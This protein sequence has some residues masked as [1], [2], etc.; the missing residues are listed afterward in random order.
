MLHK[1][2]LRTVVRAPQLFF[3]T[4][5]T[6]VTL[7]RFSQDMTLIDGALPIAA[8]T[9]LTCLWFNL[10]SGSEYMLMFCFRR[11]ELYCR[12]CPHLG[13]IWLHGIDDSWSDLFTIY[14]T[15]GISPYFTANSFPRPR[16]PKAFLQ[17]EHST[18]K[19]SLFNKT[20][21]A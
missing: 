8:V 21:S 13:P 1:I 5:D 18:G 7:N 3:S 10:F 11:N 2:L 20:L 16:S 9:S 4:T 19:K 6:G 15:E 17:F 14:P 12:D